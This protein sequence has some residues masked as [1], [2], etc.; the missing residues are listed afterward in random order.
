MYWVNGAWYAR[1]KPTPSWRFISSFTSLAHDGI[2]HVG[3]AMK[4]YGGLEIQ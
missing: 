2:D 1:P 3:D 4:V